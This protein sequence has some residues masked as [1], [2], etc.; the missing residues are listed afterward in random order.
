MKK[1]NKKKDKTIQPSSNLIMSV[2]KIQKARTSQRAKRPLCQLQAWSR[3][4]QQQ[5]RHVLLAHQTQGREVTR[6]PME[7]QCKCKDDPVRIIHPSPLKRAGR[8]RT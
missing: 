7:H 8:P 5:R 6:I 1:D 4:S 3:R 2:S